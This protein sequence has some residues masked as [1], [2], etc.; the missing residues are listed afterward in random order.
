MFPVSYTEAGNL[1]FI[2]SIPATQEEIVHKD[3][4]EFFLS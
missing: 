4:L 3:L 2:Y 1:F